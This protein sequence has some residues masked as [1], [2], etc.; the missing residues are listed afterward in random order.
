MTTLKFPRLVGAGVAA[1]VVAGVVHQAYT[2]VVGL[3]HHDGFDTEQVRCATGNI[4][5]SYR[6]RGTSGA[7][8]LVFDAGLISTSLVWRLLVDH[9]PPS[10][11]VVLYDR[12]GYRRSLRR[13]AEDY[14]LQESVSDLTDL[15]RDVADPAAPCL[16][17]G[18]SLGGYLAHRAAVE[19]TDTIAGL[20]LID[21][22]HPRE[23]LV[24]K[25]QR[26]GARSANLS[27]KLGPATMLLGGGLLMDKSG[28]MTRMEGSPYYAA[29]RLEA[30][31]YA[32]WRAAAREWGYCYPFMLDGGRPL[33][34]LDV[35]VH[36]VA[37]SGT[38][39]TIPEQRSLY[40]DYVASGEGGRL[41]TIDG[42]D[43]QTV[44]AGP[45]HAELTARALASLVADLKA[46]E[47]VPA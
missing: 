15:V 25:R 32:A 23:L 24:S 10:Y 37:A 47:V 29:L 11:T 34:H 46:S 26:E 22:N 45:K 35:P 28:I 33:D 16:L 4:I 5:T 30:S 44:V 17:V 43:H 14:C 42:A 27:I 20:L 38:L 7:P 12:A 8:I 18:H 2:T 13:C 40:E 9:L 39:T 36:V 31:T 6:R 41:E 3:R 19:L 21:P 1:G